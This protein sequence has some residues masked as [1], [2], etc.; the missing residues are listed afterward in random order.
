MESN[1]NT[2]K[3][4]IYVVDYYIDRY[5]NKI[6]NPEDD[7]KSDAIFKIIYIETTKEDIDKINNLVKKLP[8]GYDDDE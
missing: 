6:D 4:P 8:I 3:V 5:G 1:G 2:C 7:D